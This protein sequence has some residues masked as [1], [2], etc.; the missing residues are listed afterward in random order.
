MAGL[1]QAGY[2]DATVLDIGCGVGYLHQTLLQHG[3]RSATG[4]DLAPKMLQ[5]ARDWA[6]QK[7]LGDRVTYIQ[8]D[9]MTLDD[10]IGRTDV[11]LLDKV[12]CCYP[13][14]HGLVKKSLALTK[15]V[16]ALTYPR[17]R[18]FV[19]WGTRTL[20]FLL[21]LMRSD[22]RS[23]VH[24]PQAIERCI[25]AEHFEKCFQDQTAAWLTQVYVKR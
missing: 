18:W 13:D 10:R 20:G 15:R 11:C 21:W 4:I 17:D 2:R 25:N 14:A 16:Y 22:F 23:Y 24:D 6:D 1:E 5:E 12:V 19:R 3:A 8:G 7:G 9:F